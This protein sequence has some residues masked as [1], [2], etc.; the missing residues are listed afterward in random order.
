MRKNS[1]SIF[2]SRTVSVFNKTSVLDR[3]AWPCGTSRPLTSTSLISYHSESH[4]TTLQ[5]NLTPLCIYSRF[6]CLQ[7]G[8]FCFMCFRKILRLVC[9]NRSIMIKFCKIACESFYYL[10][11][12]LK[13]LNSRM[14]LCFVTSGKSLL[15]PVHIS[16]AFFDDYLSNWHHLNHFVP[17]LIPCSLNNEIQRGQTPVFRNYL[18]NIWK[19]FEKENM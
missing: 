17:I 9:W 8:S 7:I 13:D 11:H 3:R 5:S 12:Q 15:V 19:L 14:K 6:S 16:L 2:P 10:L 18:E 4:V 1:W